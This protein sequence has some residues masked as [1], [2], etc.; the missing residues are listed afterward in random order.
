MRAQNVHFRIYIKQYNEH[1]AQ[2]VCVQFM[3]TKLKK[4]NRRNATHENE[5]EKKKITKKSQTVWS[6]LFFIPFAVCHRQ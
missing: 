2:N 1:R 5:F 3:Q 4:K 6:L